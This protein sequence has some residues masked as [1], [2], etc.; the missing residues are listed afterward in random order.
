MKIIECEICKKMIRPGQHYFMVY[1]GHPQWVGDNDTA[2]IQWDLVR[3]YFHSDCCNKP[4]EYMKL[5]KE[6]YDNF[7]W[8]IRGEY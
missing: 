7:E 3:K 6:L 4:S 8:H 1:S 5:T 2:E